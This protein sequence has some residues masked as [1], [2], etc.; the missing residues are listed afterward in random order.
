MLRY[1][2]VLAAMLALPATALAATPPKG[3]ASS[4][5]SADARKAAPEPAESIDAMLAIL[6]RF[7]PAGPEPEPER[8][9][10]ARQVSLTMFPQG[11]YGEAM[12]GF[13]DRTAERVLNMSEADFAA[14]A[15]KSKDKPAK[16]SKARALPPPSTE[17]LRLSLA[18]KDPAFEAKV[19]AGKAFAKVM[20]DRFGAVAEPKFRE[21]MARS[22]ARKFDARQLAEI[23][24]FLATPTGAAFGRQMIGLWFEPDVFRST[25]QALPDLVTMLP[26]M[27]QEAAALDAKMRSDGKPKP[28]NRND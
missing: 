3:S 8:L 19:A 24:A 6:D 18:R 27:A 1:P 10:L 22:L 5:S 12:N 15:P 26:G 11:A 28:G 13:L 20:I 23:Q 25:F 14:L 21:G 9:A 17:P 4:G 16:G 2:M 7:F